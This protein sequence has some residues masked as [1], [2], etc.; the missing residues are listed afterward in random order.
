MTFSETLIIEAVKAGLA[1]GILGLTWFVG[2]RIVSRW[3][4]KRKAREFDLTITTQF[5][6]LFGEFKE[7]WRLWKV[8]RNNADPSA[9]PIP[10]NMRWHLLTRASAAEGRVESIFVKL[11][12]ERTL[13][14]AEIKDLGLFR[15][16]YQLLRQGIRDNHPLNYGYKDCEYRLF[17]ELGCKVAH[18]LSGSASHDRPTVEQ[19][20]KAFEAILA[21]RTE[22]WQDSVREMKTR[23]CK[24]VHPAA[25]ASLQRKT[26]GPAS[27]PAG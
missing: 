8:L 5:H 10:D 23:P 17:N 25:A 18:I 6:Q 13:T 20:R 3:E 21:V 15:Q 1:V 16:A 14:E 24:S 19:A 2:Q 7:I 9:L 22:D 26:N 4:L 27:V 11:A 12:T